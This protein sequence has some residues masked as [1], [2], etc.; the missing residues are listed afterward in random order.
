M[1]GRMPSFNQMLE[2]TPPLELS[3]LKAG[4]ALIV[5]STEGTKPGEVTAIDVLAGVEPILQAQPKGSQNVRLGPWNMS[6]SGGGGGEGQGMGGGMG[7]GG[8]G[9]G[10]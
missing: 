1:G 6:T 7:Q 4:Q 5:V 10:M 2:R 9:G 3:S 8:G